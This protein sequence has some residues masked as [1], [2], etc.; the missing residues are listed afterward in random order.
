MLCHLNDIGPNLLLRYIPRGKRI[1]GTCGRAVKRPRRVATSRGADK[2]FS[3]PV[4]G[5]RWC[6]L[7]PDHP[8]MCEV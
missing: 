8:V 6:V 4:N 2:M 7:F 3:N 5:V 1:V